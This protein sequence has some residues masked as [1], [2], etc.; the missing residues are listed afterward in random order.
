[1]KK[2]GKVREALNETVAGN[3]KEAQDR[4]KSNFKKRQTET[5]FK[6]RHRD[7]RKSPT[8]SNQDDHKFSKIKLR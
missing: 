5:V 8:Q 1:M 4:Q 6:E 3:I 2:I 7:F